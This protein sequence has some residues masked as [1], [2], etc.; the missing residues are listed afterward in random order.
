[1]L[2]RSFAGPRPSLSIFSPMYE[3]EQKNVQISKEIASELLSVMQ[4]ASLLT[5]SW[6]DWQNCC[7]KPF[8]SIQ[9][10]Y[11]ACPTLN[12]T[13]GAVVYSA[14]AEQ[15][16]EKYAH[17]NAVHVLTMMR[18]LTLESRPSRTVRWILVIWNRN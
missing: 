16:A 13:G 1:M 14:V 6:C 8:H 7:L 11:D 12:L 15:L 17:V 18:R 10:A 2:L 4:L 5:H 3:K 9:I